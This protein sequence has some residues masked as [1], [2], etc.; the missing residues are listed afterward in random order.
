MQEILSACTLFK[1]GGLKNNRI[2]L[3]Y[4]SGGWK[5]Q[6]HAQ[7]EEIFGK[8]KGLGGGK[9]VFGA[10]RVAGP[11]AAV[12]FLDVAVDVEVTGLGDCRHGDVLVGL[13]QEAS[14]AVQER[15]KGG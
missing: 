4:H 14:S 2:I 15:V 11:A 3:S 6:G 1:H 5:G 12:G 9:P 8:Y 7:W 13:P 10:E